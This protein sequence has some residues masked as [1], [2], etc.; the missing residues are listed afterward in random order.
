MLPFSRSELSF[1]R[2]SVRL[3][4]LEREIPGPEGSAAAPSPGSLLFFL[5]GVP[6]G[7]LAALALTAS[8]GGFLSFS[9]RM[10]RG[11]PWASSPSQSALGALYPR[12]NLCLTVLQAKYLE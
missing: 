10:K 7:L 2:D 8:A 11:A 9:S 12:T 3:E 5:P 1:C 4:M 6:A